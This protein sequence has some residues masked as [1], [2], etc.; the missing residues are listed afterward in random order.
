MTNAKIKRDDVISEVEFE[1]LIK[2]VLTRTYPH[3]YYRSVDL[4]LLAVL[5]LTGKR[6]SEVVRL[7][8][9]DVVMR[10]GFLLLAFYVGKK[11]EG[12]RHTLRREK[13]IDLDARYVEHILNHKWVLNRIAPESEWMFPRT[14]YSN[15]GGAFKVRS[16]NHFSRQTGHNRLKSISENIFAHLFRDTMGAQVAREDG[17]IVG[18]FKVMVR[19]DLEST[20]SAMRYVRRYAIDEIKQEEGAQEL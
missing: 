2:F 17:S 3:P 13:K 1:N 18:V 16:E 4:C 11:R 15:F 12:Q 14:Y 6:I 9:A 19:L 8:V 7:K 5:K 10:D 20:T